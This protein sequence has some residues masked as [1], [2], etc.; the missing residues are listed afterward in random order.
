VRGCIGVLVLAAVFTILAV[1][2][3]VP[4]LAEAMVRAGLVASG[5]EGEDIEVRI[6]AH[7]LQL[8][9]GRADA[10]RIRARDARV[11]GLSAVQLDLTL[12]DVG[13]IDRS[14]A[15]MRGRLDGVEVTAPD[16]SVLPIASAD[17]D[18]P[19]NGARARLLVTPLAIE[20]LIG[21]LLGGRF[22]S[23]PAGIRLAPPDE[24]R[25]EIR[26]FTAQG[27]LAVRPSGDLVLRTTFLGEQSITVLTADEVEPLTLTG[28]AADESGLVLLGM[29]DATSLLP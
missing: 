10:V 18:G 3:V 19:V 9:T 22:G 13:L 15:A 16:G 26:G 4:P 6:D 27:R 7:P 23:S 1:G 25:F 24:I 28:L 5:F 12:L 29:L 17:L 8:L 21:R 20:G 11:G 14:A 2:L